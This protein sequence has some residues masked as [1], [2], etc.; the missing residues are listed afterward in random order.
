M[1]VPAAAAVLLAAT[2]VPAAAGGGQAEVF[3]DRGAVASLVSANF[4]A[5]TQVA[6]PAVGNVAVRFV[7]PESVAFVDGSVEARIG[8][9]VPDLGLAGSALCRFV[10]EV[11]AAGDVV[12]LRV[13]SALPDGPL[14]MLPNLAGLIPPI[15]VQG[16]YSWMSP[17]PR[18]GQTAFGLKILAIT[19]LKDRLQLRLGLT[20]D[21][22]AR[23][24]AR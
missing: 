20:A 1:R 14:S 23:K 24:A 7:P 12:R 15:D 6:V 5:G 11:S 13:A 8:V 22:A 4:P 3:L 17:D 18:G 16:G 10:P 21:T 9:R 19:I 2:A